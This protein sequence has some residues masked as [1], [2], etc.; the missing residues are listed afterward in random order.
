MKNNNFWS[1][2]KR[3]TGCWE[4]QASCYTDGYGRYI[5]NRTI[6]CAH[7]VSYEMGHDPI[8]KGMLVCHTCDNPPCVRPSHLFLGTYKDNMIDAS[9]KGRMCRGEENNKSKLTEKDVKGI[10]SDTRSHRTIARDYSV[11]HNVIGKIKRR[12][13]WKHVL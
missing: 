4:W 3:G 1:K 10:L 9:R 7:R 12:Q 8:P 11:S 6:R 5:I 13:T 2:V